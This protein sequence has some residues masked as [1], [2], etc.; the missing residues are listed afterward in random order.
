VLKDGSVIVEGGEYTYNVDGTSQGRTRTNMGAI[1]DPTKGPIGADGTPVGA[2]TPVL[3]PL[4]PTRADPFAVWPNIGD[5]PSIVLDDGTFMLGNIFSK[6]SAVL[7]E[8]TLKWKIVD[9]TGKS[10]RNSEEGWTLLPGGNVLTIDTG[11]PIAG[12]PNNSE[13]FNPGATP[14]TTA[15]NGTWTT[16][17]S[18]VRALSY[19]ACAPKQLHEIGPAVLRP[20]GTVFATGVNTCGGAG[21]TAIYDTKTG[22]GQGAK[23]YPVM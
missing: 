11:N 21:H 5:A 3:A 10:D 12:L 13:I 19:L 7:D 9:A 15:V 22:P 8:A 2:W 17:H 16:A 20:D 18:T 14:A 6:T 23:T 4:V 1:F